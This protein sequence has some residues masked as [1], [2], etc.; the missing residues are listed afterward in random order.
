MGEWVLI[1]K[2]KTDYYHSAQRTSIVFRRFETWEK[3]DAYTADAYDQV[4]D[5]LSIETI[6]SGRVD[7]VNVKEE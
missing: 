7:S 2:C 1:L 4:D 5:C 6:Y 3:M